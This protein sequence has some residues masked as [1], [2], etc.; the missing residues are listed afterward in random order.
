[1][2]AAEY[3]SLPSAMLFWQG[4]ADIYRENNQGR[5]ALDLVAGNG[6]WDETNP[7]KQFFGK[8]IR[9]K[10]SEA[11]C[12]ANH[13]RLGGDSHAYMLHKEVLKMIHDRIHGVEQE[14]SKDNV[15]GHIGN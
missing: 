8:Y 15:F 2:I 11:F 3:R 7:V 9:Q 13:K 10:R 5:S 6:E 1:M 14:E 4:G 12:M